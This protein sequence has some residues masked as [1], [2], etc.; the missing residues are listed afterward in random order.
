MKVELTEDQKRELKAELCRS[1]GNSDVKIVILQRGWVAVGRY[2][3]DGDECTLTD[4]SVV[5]IWGTKKGLGEIAEGGP[6]SDTKLD[7][8]PTLRFHRLTVIATMD[9]V[10]GKWSKHL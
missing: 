3:Q 2:K 4:A 10:E 6:T 5:R 9:C 1:N 7:K 8:C